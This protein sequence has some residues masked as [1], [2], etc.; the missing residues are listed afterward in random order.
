MVLVLVVTGYDKSDNGL[1]ERFK[2]C[3]MSALETI[4]KKYV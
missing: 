2:T 4:E 1:R 3:G